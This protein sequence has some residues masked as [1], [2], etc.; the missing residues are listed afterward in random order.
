VF[1]IALVLAGFIYIALP[2]L[3]IAGIILLVMKVIS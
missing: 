3:I 2:V 1:L